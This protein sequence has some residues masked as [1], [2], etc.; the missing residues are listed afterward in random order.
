MFASGKLTRWSKLKCLVVLAGAA[1]FAPAGAAAQDCRLS[2]QA[3]PQVIYSGQRADVSVLARFP[4]PPTPN[5][6]YAFAAAEFDVLATDAMWS[7]ASDGVIVGSDVLGIQVGQPHQPQVGIYADPSNP[8]RV[9]RGVF[10]PQVDG[11]A[12]VEMVVDPLMFAV[13]PSKLTSSWVEC[14]A[15]GGNDFVFVNPLRVGGWLAAPAE[16]TSIQVSDDVV[17]DGRIITGENWD[18]ASVGTVWTGSILLDSTTVVGFDRQPETFSATVQVNDAQR[19]RVGSLTVTFSGLETGGYALSA[20]RIWEYTPC[21]DESA[22]EGFL[23]GVRVAAGDLDGDGNHGA[24]QLV[25]GSVPQTVE[26]SAGTG[27]LRSMDGGSTW[28]LRYDRP[29]VA[30][31]R[32]PNGQPQVVTVDRIDVHGTREGAARLSSQNNLKQLLLGAHV[33]EATGVERMTITPSQDE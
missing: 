20:N 28:T 11:P 7:F 4:A 29:V 22:Y 8:I 25:V 15:A 13:Y 32:G 21:C 19:S 5:A 18:S 2:V 17:I 12:L 30:V 6:P 9:W 10:E 16:G 26:A 24:P 27:V 1:G 14:D 23:G 31:V 3:T 33:F